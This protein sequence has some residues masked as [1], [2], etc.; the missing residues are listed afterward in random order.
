MSFTTNRTY[1]LKPGK[2]YDP[3]SNG[4]K[5]Y[6]FTGATVAGSSLISG[7]GQGAV[8]AMNQIAAIVGASG[9]PVIEGGPF[10][11][12]IGV[13]VTG[14]TGLNYFSVSGATA[15]TSGTYTFR[16]FN[17]DVP[18]TTDS[19]ILAFHV[20][21]DP[22]AVTMVTLSDNTIAFP[23]GALSA[24]GVYEYGV[25]SITSLGT[26]GALLGLAPATRPFTY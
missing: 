14:L 8:S 18:N 5:P 21:A 19:P 17:G 23:S 26:T 20:L 7:T 6:S 25:K 10:T 13:G 2:N 4:N 1:V 15:T 3:A 12:R 9:T 11:G 24:K 16:V 22:G